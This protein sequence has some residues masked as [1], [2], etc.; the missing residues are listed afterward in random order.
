MQPAVCRYTVKTDAVNCRS[1]MSDMAIELTTIFKVPHIR[2]ADAAVFA[3]HLEEA[4]GK[5]LEEEK[6]AGITAYFVSPAG[7][8]N[9]LKVGMRFE[10]MNE[11]YLSD[12]AS[13]MLGLAV[14]RVDHSGTET[15]LHSPIMKLSSQLVSA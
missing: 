1:E 11:D 6:M 7:K 12:T 13:E 15:T 8:S 14:E 2:A 5:I 3:C 4:L 9:A 10:D